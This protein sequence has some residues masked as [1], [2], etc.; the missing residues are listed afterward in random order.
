VELVARRGREERVVRDALPEKE[1]EARRHRVGLDGHDAPGQRDGD[2]L[3]AVE[4][5]RRLEHRA[6]RELSGTLEVD[7]LSPALKPRYEA[8]ALVS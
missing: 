4:K 1:R 6:Q 5:L 3:D 2:R 7:G 8:L